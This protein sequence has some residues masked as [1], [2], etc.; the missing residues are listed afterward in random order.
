MKKRSQIKNSLWE[1]IGETMYYT[2]IQG[3]SVQA[4]YYYVSNNVWHRLSL[5]LYKS[6]EANLIKALK[7][8]Y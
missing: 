3:S 1:R 5:P 7:N 8:D 4:V 2:Q 6:L